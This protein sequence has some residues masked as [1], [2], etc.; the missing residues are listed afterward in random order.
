M[1]GLRKATVAHRYFSQD[2]ES[3]GA[4]RSMRPRPHPDSLVGPLSI[5]PLLAR[6]RY[7]VCPRRAPSEAAAEIVR[8]IASKRK[9]PDVLLGVTGHNGPV[10]PEGEVVESVDELSSHQAGTPATVCSLTIAE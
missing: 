5:P 9:S 4:D 10:G 7:E 1:K 2:A 6:C 3:Y 8:E